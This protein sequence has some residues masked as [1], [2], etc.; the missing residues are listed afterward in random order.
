M[1]HRA[2]PQTTEQAP[3]EQPVATPVDTSRGPN[4]IS[5]HIVIDGVMLSP[6]EHACRIQMDQKAITNIIDAAMLRD[7]E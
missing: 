7:D 6:E 1:I 3:Q 4:V 2:E 5:P